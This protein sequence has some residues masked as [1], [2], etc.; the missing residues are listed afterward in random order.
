MA[1]K[2]CL[3]CGKPLKYKKIKGRLYRVAYCPD[4]NK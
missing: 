4:C 2:N 3:N 1:Q